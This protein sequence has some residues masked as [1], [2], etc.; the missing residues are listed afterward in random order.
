MRLT[1][2]FLLVCLCFIQ[3]TTEQATNPQ[4]EAT[5]KALPK[6]APPVP[7]A[8]IAFQRFEIDAEAGGS[9]ELPNGSKVTIPSQALVD[10]TGQPVTGIVSVNYREFHDV[11]DIL[12]SG[13]PMNYDSAGISQ[14]FQSAGMMEIRA[15]QGEKP[16]FIADGKLVD[17][18]MNSLRDGNYN[19]Y[20]WDSTAGNWTYLEENIPLAIASLTP[21][22][23]TV[24]PL[25]DS[26]ELERYSD[27]TESLP[28]LPQVPIKASEDGVVFYFETDYEAY[29]LL[30]PFKDIEWE[31]V[32][33]GKK[34]YLTAKQAKEALKIVWNSAK[35]LPYEAD[36]GLYCLQ[37]RNRTKKARVITKAVQSGDSYDEAMALYE[38]LAQKHKEAKLAEIRRRTELRL[39]AERETARLKAQR[40][41]VRNFQI[42]RF[43]IYNCDRILNLSNSRN[44]MA[45]FDIDTSGFDQMTNVNTVYLIL[46]TQNALI[47]YNLS[48]SLQDFSYLPDE[49]NILAVL[50]P[51]NELALF[52]AQD[53]AT[54][55]IGQEHRFALRPT[56]TIVNSVADVRGL[57]E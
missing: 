32:E 20:N 55:D 48:D 10:A 18:S 50:L 36:Q 16:V 52:D 17:V 40:T 39:A 9:F 4:A 34:G 23:D 14:P 2:L 31:V 5:P 45:A 29:P 46:P 42:R 28:P 38:E 1:L 6:V 22:V 37:L 53:F 21:S 41:F 8:D 15:F 47:D 26:N 56:G 33:T 57:F 11:A 27:E 19:L 7:G 13:I 3:C 12:L 49:P 35:V 43:G 30:A 44:I 51:G 54:S 24:A 25:P